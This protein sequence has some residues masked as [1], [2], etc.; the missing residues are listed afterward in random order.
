MSDS[1]PRYRAHLVVKTY[2]TPP[3]PAPP[4]RQSYLLSENITLS[5]ANAAAKQILEASLQP[6]MTLTECG[7]DVPGAGLWKLGNDGD[8]MAY[9]ELEGG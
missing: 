8:C 3:D 9:V 5:A 4:V 2:R 6:G 7:G 1:E